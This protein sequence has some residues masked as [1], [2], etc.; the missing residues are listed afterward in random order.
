MIQQAIDEHTYCL[1]VLEGQVKLSWDKA[2]EAAAKDIFTI[3]FPLYLLS[4]TNSMAATSWP[5]V[6]V[7]IVW[8]YIMIIVL[9]TAHTLGT[10]IE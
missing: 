1:G 3:D 4:L 7:L 10:K 9:H 6:H 5:I 8:A 2:S